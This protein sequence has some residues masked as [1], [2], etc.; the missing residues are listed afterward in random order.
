[1]AFIPPATSSR[2][3]FVRT[4]EKVMDSNTWTAATTPRVMGTNPRELGTNPRARGTNPR[5]LGANP[6]ALGTNPRPIGTNPKAVYSTIKTET[7]QITQLA[8]KIRPPF[9]VP[10]K[11][12]WPKDMLPV[13]EFPG[14]GPS[15]QALSL[16]LLEQVEAQ[17]RDQESRS[18]RGSTRNDEVRKI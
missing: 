8:E 16:E 9:G 7:S 10:R 11:R 18:K 1:M 14:L 17:I 4:N 2:T 12:V 3:P 13:D 5:A 6:R 15:T